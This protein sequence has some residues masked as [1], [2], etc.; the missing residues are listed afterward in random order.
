MAKRTQSVARLLWL[1]ESG[2]QELLLHPEDSV[3]IGRGDA[4][5]I[6]INSARVSRNHARIEWK[7]DGFFIR[8][9]SSSNGT[10]VNGQRIEYMPWGLQDGDL[11]MLER[12]PIHFEEISLPRAEQYINTL[13]TVPMAKQGEEI[14]KPRLVISQGNEVGQE[15]TI[16]DDELIIGRESGNATWKVRIKDN[17]VSRPHARI[18]RNKGVYTLIDLGS[19]N[20]TTLNDNFVI[21]PVPLKDGDTIGIG[22]TRLVFRLT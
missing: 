21:A 9:L 18:E 8:D 5:T 3:S 4:N 10:F 17:T 22:S 13:P 15:I 1:T 11:I 20:G 14:R 16:D 2:Q 6:V 19:A 7:D 12:V